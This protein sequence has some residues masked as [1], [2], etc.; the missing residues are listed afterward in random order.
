MIDGFDTAGLIG[1]TAMYGAVTLVGLVRVVGFP[2]AKA[3]D[4][5][6]SGHGLDPAGAGRAR[7]VTYLRRARR[8]RTAGFLLGFNAPYAWMWVTRSAYRMNDV[9]PYLWL[10]GFAAGILLA[11]LLRPRADGS[12]AAVEPRRL[13]Q[14]LPDFTR[15]D[16]WI[17]LGGVA[18]LVLLSR[19]L[20]VAPAASPD[21][22]AIS[23]NSLGWYAGLGLL[24]GGIVFAAWIGQEIVIRRRQSLDDVEE[25]RADDAMRSTSVQ[26]IAGLGYGAPMWLAATMAWNL[27]ITQRGVVTSILALS[28]ILLM[29]GGLG[30]LVGYPRLNGRWVVPRARHG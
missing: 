20:P 16:R 27:A 9:F 17:L 18:A 30:M 1:A 19:L 2:G 12:A 25:I 15:F 6:M 7:I 5:W 29:V 13:A 28:S 10:V 26:G 4:A 24:A 22:S 21:E 8:I 3:V 14:Y 23:R 11:E